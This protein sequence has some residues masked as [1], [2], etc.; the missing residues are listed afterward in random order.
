VEGWFSCG[1]AE[2]ARQTEKTSQDFS[3]RATDACER[4]FSYLRSLEK[5]AIPR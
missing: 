5:Q 4:A 1:N 2:G 3:I